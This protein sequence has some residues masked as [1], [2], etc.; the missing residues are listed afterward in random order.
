MFDD[1]IRFCY[2]WRDYQA[3]V[4][5]DA[6]Q[7]IQDGKLHV[8]AAPGSGKTVL[9]L[10]LMR[11]I[12]KPT[13][14]LA[15]TIAIRNQW[16]DRF[17][18][19]FVTDKKQPKWVS[20]D[21]DKPAYV[22]IVTYQ[23]LASRMLAKTD[24]K[25]KAEQEVP[26]EE[27][28]IEP[29][30]EEAEA[31]SDATVA[32][33][34]PSIEASVVVENI[35]E[36]IYVPGEEPEPVAATVA[37]PE[38]VPE[39]VKE[40]P[41]LLKRLREIGTQ[42]IIVDEA[43]HLR[44]EWWRALTALREGLNKSVVVALT[45][46]PPYDADAL[47]WKRYSTFCGPVDIE[48][49]VPELV[50]R[51]ELC[52]HQD[53]IYYALPS[54]EEIAAVSTIRHTIASFAHDLLQDQSFIAALLQHPACSKVSP[55]RER[56]ILEEP[57]YYTAMASFL[58]AAGHKKPAKP[59]LRL[60][61]GR[62]F[63]RL[64][65]F[66]SQQLEL[67]LQGVLYSDRNF[68][69]ESNKAL[70]ERLQ[71]SAKQIGLV[72]ARQ[73]TVV[74][75]KKIASV[76]RNSLS[77][78]QA[79][80]DIVAFE[81]EKLGSD[82]RCVVL[83]DYIRKEYIEPSTQASKKSGLVGVLP[84]FESV[85]STTYASG[86]VPRLAVLT[87]SI[88]IVPK[89]LQEELKKSLRARLR[90]AKTR[91]VK[92]S[93]VDYKTDPAYSVCTIADSARQHTVAVMTELF[94]QGKLQII[95]GTKSLLGEG[96]DAPSINT[97]LLA[98]FVGTS[99][100]SNQMRGRAIRVS[101]AD[102]HKTASIW[103]V[104]TI[105]PENMGFNPLQ[106]KT[107]DDLGEEYR[108][109]KRR[110][111]T[112]VAPSYTSGRI[113]SGLERATFLPPGPYLVRNLFASAEAANAQC[114]SLAG[115]RAQIAEL[116][117]TALS[118]SSVGQITHSMS[119]DT[120]RLP[121]GAVIFRGF[122]AGL[123][124]AFISFIM[125]APETI[126]FWA[127]IVRN[128]GDGGFAVMVIGV[129]IA[130]LI[131]VFKALRIMLRMFRH[132]SPERSMKQVGEALL[133]TLSRGG[134]I[135]TPLSAMRVETKRHTDGSVETLLVGAQPYESDIFLDAL[136]DLISPV[137]NPRYLLQARGKNWFI[138]A[139]WNSFAMPAILSQKR[140]HVDMLLSEWQRRVGP[141][142]GVYTRSELGR[143]IVLAARRNSLSAY[144]HQ[145]VE[146]RSV[147]S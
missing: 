124:A 40:E 141:C 56:I 26:A 82:I 43:H 113:E 85:R 115:E 104:L 70:V 99:M 97:L 145:G 33:M 94:E 28:Y 84:I 143:K 2:E 90:S 77:K 114:F 74:D 57:E 14:I 126:R 27:L 5:K 49:S 93:F 112:F 75:N 50:A 35:D 46:T 128:S 118:A 101:K 41:T 120:V 89:E 39:S 65:K 12:N 54:T 30:E 8:V 109:L 146:R 142:R 67:L 64:P 48:V 66:D 51:H 139:G 4:L 132:F 15:P 95:V 16:V 81:Y 69:S 1:S 116:W 62:R 22:T 13:I 80:C 129:A 36:T 9:G 125:F 110:F 25:R 58:R 17:T 55:D 121:R 127:Q 76:L 42:A 45:A 34:E 18:E 147:W 52:P 59:L 130:L 79:I 144:Y 140:K 119:A 106:G 111:G 138:P 20:T 96:W 37:M 21:I 60:I 92:L 44:N 32:A 23:G 6:Q 73:V 103:H 122:A 107:A 3:R 87:G 136:S 131:S 102:L 100:L 24:K 10:E 108:T 123:Y 53:Y 68:M 86:E 63:S 47:E 134:F 137:R 29:E 72:E 133:A 135:T 71:T 31:V 91:G 117:Q 38:T 61:C 7:F 19:L 88:V 98:S 105:V 11:R 78:L 83:T